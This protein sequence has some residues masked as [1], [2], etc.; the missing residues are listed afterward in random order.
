MKRLLL[1]F[2]L[3]PSIAFAAAPTRGFNYT[4]HTTID[5]TQNNANENALYSYLQAGVDTYAS[6]SLTNDAVSGSAAISYSKLNLIGSI[7][8]ADISP[9]AAIVGSKLDLSTPGIIGGT[10]PAAG[11]FTTLTANTALVS[12]TATTLN[13][14]V[15][16]GSTHQGDIFY[17]NGSSVVRLTP[18]TSGQ[19][20]LTGGTAA[21]PSWG[22]GG[23]LQLISVTPVS[24]AT[25]S[26]NI[27]ITV[28]NNYLVIVNLK[29]VSVG[30]NAIGILINGD[31]GS[32]YFSGYSGRGALA[33][34]GASSNGGTSFIT[35]TTVVAS[36][37]ASLNFNLT[38]NLVDTNSEFISGNLFGQ[39]TTAGDGGVS[40]FGGKYTGAAP[41][42]SFAV[43]GSGNYTGTVYLYKYILS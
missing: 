1:M 31:G 7:T 5:P 3:L 10:S 33:A 30:A 17:D 32:N 36:K 14:T 2:L 19:A 9:T 23:A 39:L 4:A 34:I 43:I 6:G 20:L 15:N 11:T 28:S 16:L 18:G 8:N 26:G 29:D 22:T 27:A 24:A 13:G 38:S 41:P 21:N 40:T 42:T 25:T 12:S 35:G 37:G